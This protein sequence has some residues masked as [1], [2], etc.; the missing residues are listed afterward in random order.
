MID[1]GKRNVL[2]VRVDALDYDAAVARVVEA[3]QKR[4]PYACTAL[5]VHGLMTGVLDREQQYRLNSLDLVTPD[6]QPVRWALNSL[7]GTAL[8]DRVYGP[9][10]M[11]KVCEVAA[12]RELPIYLYG[13]T[14]ATVK[15]LSENLVK[16][17]PGIQIAG[18]DPSLFRAF[19]GA[20]RESFYGR[21]RDS[22]ARLVFVG[23]GCPRQEVFAY[24]CAR[25]LGMPVISV[26]AAFDYHAGV[27]PEP[28]AVVQRMG[29]Q[30]LVRL[31]QDPRRLWKRY[32]VYNSLFVLLFLA[33]RVGVWR[34]KE[35]GI[36][37][38]EE[39]MYG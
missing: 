18:A 24:E 15:T 31:L 36:P 6:G 14:A 26:G 35:A 17:F 29:M 23:L 7:Y 8:P 39:L 1:V 34:P 5:A 19:T 2:G 12:E 25:Q 28:P 22:G 9:N 16:R 33:Q 38:R 27:V 32:V 21:V 3:A 37:P 10:L 4:E 11:L 20:E 30:W 13:A